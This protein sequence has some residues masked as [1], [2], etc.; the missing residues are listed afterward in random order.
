MTANFAKIVKSRLSLQVG[1]ERNLG[2]ILLPLPWPKSFKWNN[3]HQIFWYR[4]SWNCLV[5][6]LEGE[7]ATNCKRLPLLY[8]THKKRFSPLQ[9][10]LYTASFCPQFTYTHNSHWYQW[11][12]Q[13]CGWEQNLAHWAA[14]LGILLL[15]MTTSELDSLAYEL[16][17]ES[18]GFPF[19]FFLFIL[20]LKYKMET[21]ETTGSNGFLA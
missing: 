10:Y 16:L 5:T 14:R 7:T 15:T 21:R 20:A 18:L 19:S 13:T 12:L 17:E 6:L 2:Q 11:K 9:S 3:Y 8:Q 1:N 4:I